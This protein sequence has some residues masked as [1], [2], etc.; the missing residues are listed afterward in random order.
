MVEEEGRELV[1]VD[2]VLL[3]LKVTYLLDKYTTITLN[4]YHT[5]HV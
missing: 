1:G 5:I 3:N 2:V 4:N